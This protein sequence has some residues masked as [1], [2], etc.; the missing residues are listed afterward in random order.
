MTSPK[1]RILCTDDDPDTR[2]LI[3]TILNHHGFE[4]TCTDGADQALRLAKNKQFDLYLLDHWMPCVS[5]LDLAR[6]LREFDPHTPILFFSGA[7]RDVDKRAAQ[8]AGAQAY[9][10]KPASPDMLLAEINR[11]I[12][13]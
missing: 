12:S 8:E 1:G 2:D 6:E 10:V 4:V 13:H 11:L 7:A 3:I 5:G 9:L